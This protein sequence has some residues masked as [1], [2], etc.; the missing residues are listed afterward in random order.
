MHY[1]N[2]EYSKMIHELVVPENLNRKEKEMRYGQLIE[3]LKLNTPDKLFRFRSCKERTFSEL[4]KDILSFSPAYMMNDDFDGM[5]YFNKKQIEESFNNVLKKENIAR[6]KDMFNQGYIPPT[7]SSHV[8]KTIIDNGISMLNE[9]N[10]DY[11]NN[12]KQLVNDIFSEQS[13]YHS[14]LTH[15]KIACLSTNIN[16]A[17]MWGYYANNG[18]GFALSYDFTKMSFLEYGL[19]PVIYGEKRF[20]ATS[21]A[22][23]LFQQK[24][25]VRFSKDVSMYKEYSNIIPCPDEFMSIKVLIHKSSVWSHEQEWRL[26]FNDSKARQEEKYPYI[27][28]KPN[29]IY[30]GR[31]ISE[32]NEKFLRRIAEEKRIPIY[33]MEIREN[34]PNYNFYPQ[35]L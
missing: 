3:Y 11:I 7:V 15:K 29:A 1:M 23:W 25:L 8:S 2:C 34:D 6:M 28:K 16:S 5:L 32:I 26:I 22:R 20:D 13:S 27:I 30:L 12:F 14:I 24:T 17:A 19:Y 35:K 33:K 10:L 4:D 18:T 31:N 21:F 9:K